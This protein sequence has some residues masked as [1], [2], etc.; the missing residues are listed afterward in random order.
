MHTALPLHFLF[1]FPL[2]C[3][4]RGRQ[5]DFFYLSGDNQEQQLH[6]LPNSSVA[7]R[8]NRTKEETADRRFFFGGGQRRLRTV[9]VVEYEA[10]CFLLLVL[11]FS[12][13]SRTQIRLNI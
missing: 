2:S 9:S 4:A 6:N 10:F 7:T 13:L 1:D 12:L 11:V 5:P 8:G 3:F